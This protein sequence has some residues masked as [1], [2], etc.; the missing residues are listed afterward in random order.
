[1]ATASLWLKAAPKLHSNLSLFVEGW[2][3]NQQLFH[4]DETEEQLREAYLDIHF[5][6]MDFRIGK[7]IIVWGR[8]DRINPTDNKSTGFYF[9]RSGR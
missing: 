8:T 6:P 7:Q 3:M 9:A 5:G 1:L 2:I 4:A